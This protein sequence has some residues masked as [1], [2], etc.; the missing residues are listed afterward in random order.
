M[1]RSVDVEAT[2][3]MQKANFVAT[4]VMQRA[5][6]VTLRRHCQELVLAEL[7]NA[8]GVYFV[9]VTVLPL[10]ASKLASQLAKLQETS[11]LPT[12]EGERPRLLP[13]AL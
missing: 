4:L 9:K 5:N 7:A 11:V 2:V 3:V 8:V 13:V 10:P 1:K 6:F 12:A